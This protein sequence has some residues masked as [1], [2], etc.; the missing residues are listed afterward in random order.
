V[1]YFEQLKALCGELNIL[2]PLRALKKIST[3]AGITPDELVDSVR[4]FPIVH[5]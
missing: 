3:Q 5:Q 4:F 2:R 1:L